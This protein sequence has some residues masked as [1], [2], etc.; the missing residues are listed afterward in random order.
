MYVAGI[1]IVTLLAWYIGKTNKKEGPPWLIITFV[2]ICPR[3]TSFPAFF[4]VTNKDK[5]M[6]SR[7]NNNTF[8]LLLLQIFTFVASARKYCEPTNGTCWPT[9]DDFNDL[10]SALNPE[11]SRI[12]KYNLGNS[13]LPAAIPIYS[14]YNQLVLRSLRLNSISVLVLI[15]SIRSPYSFR[16][17]S[18]SVVG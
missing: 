17:N 2:Q 8:F 12:C 14:P 10:V 5:M 4:W 9:Q 16:L 3:S 15:D 13:T 18:F 11:S 7:W 6:L 1:Y